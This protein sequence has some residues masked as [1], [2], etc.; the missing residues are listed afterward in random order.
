MNT[1]DF[2][3]IGAGIIGL[4]VAKQL[5]EQFPHAKIALLEKEKKIGLH[6]SGRNSGVLHSGIYYPEDSLK[7]AV[8]AKGAE[9]MRSFAREHHISCVTTGKVIIA[10]SENDLLS[11]ERLLKNAADNKVRAERL[12]EDE[13]KRIE[14]YASVFQQGIYTPDT[15]SIDSKKVLDILLQIILSRGVDL[16]LNHEVI[17]INEKNKYITTSRDHFSYG[18]FF[19]CA[20]AGTD[21]IAKMVN[22][23]KDYILLPFKGIYYKLKPEKNYLV[24]SHI[25]PVPNLNLPFLGVHFTR[26]IDGSIYVGP[27]AMPAF[28]RENYG[29]FKGVSKEALRIA[30]DIALLY[31]ANQQNF[32]KLIHSEIKKYAKP[33]F[34]HAAKQLVHSI[35]TED[36]QAS[37]K[38]GIR[39]QLVNT[40]KKKLEMDYIIEQSATSLHV[41][42]A[43][44][45]AFTSA[46]CFAELLVNRAYK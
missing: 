18:Y 35:Q 27:T 30:K 4:S 45:P 36:L 40:L 39:P 10:T 14:P 3:V 8:C 5:T 33:Y 34:M 24:K 44:S 9:L 29:I 32:R 7:A 20:G 13:I 31:W 15:A 42:N 11:L 2:V 28:G 19:N 16:Y 38:V 23:A 22:L 6:A 26:S 43:I 41:L 25:Y 46:F 37:S 1:Y 17:A 21:K 12:N